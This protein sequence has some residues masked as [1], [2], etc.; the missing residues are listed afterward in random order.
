MTHHWVLS[1]FNEEG[2][3]VLPQLH[4]QTHW[5]SVNFYVHLQ[6]RITVLKMY[7]FLI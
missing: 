1:L 4:V 7:V 3:S 2:L 6:K 5:L